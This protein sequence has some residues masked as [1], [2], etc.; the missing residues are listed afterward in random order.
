MAE[1]NGINSMEEYEYAGF[2]I[3]VA[4]ALIDTLLLVIVFSI[5]FT[6]IYGVDYWNPERQVQGAWDVLIQYLAPIVITV[7]FW[8]RYLGTPGKMA[9]RLRILDAR[10]GKAIST[11]KAIGRYLGYYVSAL[12]FLLGFI[13]VGI[14]KKKQGFHD[15]LAGTVV[16]RDR[17]QEAVRFE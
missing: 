2:W 12:P 6:L 15:K 13:W 1:K 17:T 5:P 4:A 8:T 16:V 11:P 10:T 3:R 7:W 9:L 14:D